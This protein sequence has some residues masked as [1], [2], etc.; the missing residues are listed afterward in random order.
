MPPQNIFQGFPFNGDFLQ[1]LQM[2]I[3]NF[4]TN[5]FGRNRRPNNMADHQYNIQYNQMGP[6]RGVFVFNADS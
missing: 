2:M 4:N 5:Q 6:R 1:Q 3:P